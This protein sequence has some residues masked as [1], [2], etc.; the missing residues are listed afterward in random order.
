[1]SLFLEMRVKMEDIIDK[2]FEKV[3]KN[4]HFF[5]EQLAKLI[6]EREILVWGGVPR[7]NHW[8]TFAEEHHLNMAGYIDSD[9]MKKELNG[10]PIWLPDEAPVENRYIIVGL[11]KSHV[12]VTEKLQTWGKKQLIDYFYFSKNQITI[13][14]CSGVYQ[15]YFGNS[16]HGVVEGFKVT[17]GTNS[18]LIIGENCK[19]DKSV[20]IILMRGATL[21]LEEG[22]CLGKECIIKVMEDGRVYLG[23]KCKVNKRAEI[24]CGKGGKIYIDQ[25][26]TFGPNL[27]IA[28]YGSNKLLLHKDCMFSSDV[29]VQMAN[30]HALIDLE[31]KKAYPRNGYLIEIGEHVWIGRRCSIRY[32]AMIGSGTMI[33]MESLV[34]EEVPKNV[35]VAGNPL[36]VIRHNIAWSR[37]RETEEGESFE[38][39]DF[40]YT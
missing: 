28:D 35:M 3:R 19:I 32:G 30:G 2:V 21:I 27:R 9:C 8:F 11:E 34:S 5:E 7:N 17:L 22:C 1:M 26:C 31:S 20:E 4:C 16:I 13:S 29:I 40:R 37:K 15:D 12:E 10:Y 36:K 6:G 23:S 39:Y 24:Q 33:G 18:T 25:E 14:Y 38:E